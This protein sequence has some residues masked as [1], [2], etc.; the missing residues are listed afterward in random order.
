MSVNLDNINSHIDIE[1]IPSILSW[2]QKYKKIIEPFNKYDIHQMIE[3][4]YQIIK[5]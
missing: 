4:K 2:I 3:M 5:Y 1:K